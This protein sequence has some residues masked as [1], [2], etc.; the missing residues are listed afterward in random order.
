[1][2]LK[3]YF[4]ILL[5]F[6]LNIGFYNGFSQKNP[7]F[8]KNKK[9]AE[10]CYRVKNYDCCI[11][12]YEVALVINETCNECKTKMDECKKKKKLLIE[13][14][15]IQK[16]KEEDEIIKNKL[17]KEN[18]KIHRKKEENDTTWIKYKEYKDSIN[19]QIEKMKVD[20]YY[21]MCKNKIVELKSDFHEINSLINELKKLSSVQ[22]NQIE[23]QSKI[24]K[25]REDSLR[26][27]VATYEDIIN[28]S[29][30][31]VQN[32]IKTLNNPIQNN[33][34]ENEAK[35]RQIK[36]QNSEI[37]HTLVN[38]YSIDAKVK[39]LVNQILEYQ[40]SIEKYKTATSQASIGGFSGWNKK[41]LSIPNVD[42]S[43][44]GKIVFKVTVDDSGDVVGISIIEATVSAVV[45]NFYKNYIQQK[46]SSVLV[47]E[48]TPPPRATGTVVINI[49][50]K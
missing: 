12:N 18:A 29:Y 20:E 40:K 15:K 21:Q 32:K 3:N 26:D 45:Q 38:L 1:M 8:E 49:F 25:T 42:S 19:F 46:L 5:V 4:K 30:S 33:K 41:K 23:T 31:K 44:T 14:T 37:T 10:F 34:V 39:V 13:N 7:D 27:R 24:F 47:A 28:N 11:S 2:K 48:G 16:K 6:S 22:N 36:S 50:S 17:I 43:E 35:L 9:E